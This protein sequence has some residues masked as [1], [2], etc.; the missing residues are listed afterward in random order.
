MN[1][2]KP[3]LSLIAVFLKLFLSG[4]CGSIWCKILLCTLT[5]CFSQHSFLVSGLILV[6]VVDVTVSVRCFFSFIHYLEAYE[7]CAIVSSFDRFF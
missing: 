2:V 5:G 3:S 1:E 6:C 4:S 7:T